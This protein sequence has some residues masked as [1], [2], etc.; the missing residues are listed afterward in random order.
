MHDAIGNPTH[1]I[2]SPDL[3]FSYDADM[4]FW[5]KV[6]SFLYNIWYRILYYWYELPRSDKI[7]RKYFGQDMPYLGDIVNNVS[8]VMLNFNPILH[9]TRPNV[10]NLIELDQIHIKKP[11][12]LPQVRDTFYYFKLQYVL[13]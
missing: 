7:A 9:S 12:P 5:V 8:L 1:P 3:I 11:K 6:D 13:N 4:N 2:G 10:P